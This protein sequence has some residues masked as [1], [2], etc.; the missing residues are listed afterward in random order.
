MIFDDP[1]GLRWKRIK[2]ISLSFLLITLLIFIL[3]WLNLYGII[4]TPLL[5]KGI[6]TT[7]K[8]ILTSYI[9]YLFL[10]IIVGFVRMFVLFYFAFRQKRRKQ[11]IQQF[12]KIHQLYLLPFRPSVSV[13]VPVYNEAVVITKT[14]DSILQSNYPVK[15]II[16]VDDGSTDETVSIIQQKFKRNPKVK[17]LQKENGG[18]ASALNLGIRQAKGKIVITIDADTMFTKTTIAHLAKNFSDPQVAAVSG[19]CKIGNRI[20]PLTIWQH[21]EYVTANNLDKRSFEEINA[22]T[23]VPGSNSAWRK[24]VIEEVGY[25]H[26]DTL[27]EDTE[28]TLRILQAGYKIVY[29]HDAMSYEECP[30]KVKDFLKQRN[31][32]SYGVLQTAWKHRKNILQSKNKALKYF[33]IPS[34]AF[35]Y[36][37]ILTSPIIDILFIISI[38]SGPRLIFL[39]TLLFYVADFMNSFIAF[40]LEKES[41]KPLVWVF[42]QRFAYRYLLAYVTWKSIIQALK[43][44]RVGWNKMKRTGTNEF[45]S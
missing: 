5:Y 38:F 42:V 34:L 31:R 7:Y 9:L 23:V 25:Y 29:E 26:H 20:N 43:G 40:F 4:S 24:S 39:F 21:I 32:W 3:Y 11:I 15:E 28:L 17:L 22:I 27:A 45:K 18:K 8:I 6:V 35:S 44:N 37:L 14:I 12:K 1:T 10:T 41:K 36:L 30:H 33:A 19:N 16:I 2:L 13:I